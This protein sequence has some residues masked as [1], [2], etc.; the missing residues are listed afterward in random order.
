MFNKYLNMEQFTYLCWDSRGVMNTK[1]NIY[2]LVLMRP[3]I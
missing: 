1:S 3:K 2:G